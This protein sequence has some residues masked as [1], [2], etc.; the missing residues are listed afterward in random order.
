[1]AGSTRIVWALWGL[2]TAAIVVTYSRV[3]PDE[4][5]HVSHEGIPGGLGRALVFV[6]FPIALV[7][8]AIAAIAADRVR[9]K[10]ADALLLVAVALCAVVTWPGVVDQADLDAKLVNVLPAIGVVLVL[11]VSLTAPDERNRIGVA[12]ATAALVLFA[13]SIPWIAAEVG[14]HVG[15]GVFLSGELRVHGSDPAPHP[16]VHLGDHHG[17]NGV[18]LAVTALLLWPALARMRRR[19]LLEVTRAYLGL[20]LAYGLVNAANDLWLEQVV[21]RGWTDREIPSGLE[22]RLAPIWAAIVL[23][24]AAIVAIDLLRTRRRRQR[25]AG[26]QAIIAT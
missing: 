26:A 6:D 8:P 17:L 14:A 22:P 9:T 15:V 24:A 12:R 1:M 19:R 25:D 23:L 18:L 3:S 16:A 10:R 5:Y 7:A 4:L 2:A 21:K 11:A 13:L 20:M